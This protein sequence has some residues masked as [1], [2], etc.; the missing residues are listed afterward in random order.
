MNIP[1]PFATPKIPLYQERT[2]GEKF[3][4]TFDFIKE[5]WRLWLKGSVYLLLPLSLVQAF[6]LNS[7]M[8][9]FM[10][11]FEGSYYGG[12]TGLLKTVF[13]YV[14][15]IIFLIAGTILM[16]S[17]LYAMMQEYQ[18]RDSRLKDVS[19][20]DLKPRIVKNFKRSLLMSLFVS[21]AVVIVFG[22]F[23]SFAIATGVFGLILLVYA[24]L[25]AVAVPLCLTMPVYIFE[26]EQRLWPAFV[27]GLSLGWETWGGTAL[28]ML[29]M[30]FIV[31]FIQ[32]VFMMPW[33]VAEIFKF[34]FI[35]EN[36]DSA[37]VNSGLYS[38]LVYL[39]GVVQSFGTYLASTVTVVAIAYQ[40]GH[41]AELRDGLSVNSDIEKFE[42]MSDDFGIENFESL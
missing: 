1:L 37:I 34:V 28:L 4:A 40:Y 42:Q 10:D 3:S 22:L 41:A 31:N 21:V 38:F 30:S 39:L 32:S 14:G 33:F 7:F 26:P 27:R 19:L 36:V 16:A 20:H 25:L 8:G 35:Q 17:F 12:G 5:N 13:S 18:E 6:T 2:F 11:A 24:A 9:S 15:F 23:M 29:V